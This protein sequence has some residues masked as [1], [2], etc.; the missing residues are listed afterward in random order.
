MDRFVL[1][2]EHFPIESGL[3]VT[4]L[5]QNQ[6]IEADSGI[7]VAIN[8]EVV[9]KTQWETQSIQPNDQVLIITATQGG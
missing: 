4:S 9:P 7:A 6:S 8:S 2:G 5:L 3:T 1:N